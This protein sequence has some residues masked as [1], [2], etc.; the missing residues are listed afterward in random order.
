[1]SGS[2]QGVREG[3]QGDRMSELRPEGRVPINQQRNIQHRDES[4]ERKQQ[5]QRP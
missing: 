4:R 3:F 2:S 1:M 5:I